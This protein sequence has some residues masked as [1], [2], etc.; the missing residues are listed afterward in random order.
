MEFFSTS[1][2]SPWEFIVRS[3][4]VY[5]ITP[6]Q[7]KWSER[8]SWNLFLRTSFTLVDGNQTEDCLA[9]IEYYYH[10][11]THCVDSCLLINTFITLSS[12]RRQDFVSNRPSAQPVSSVRCTS[13]SDRH[14]GCNNSIRV[15]QFVVFAP[16][17][18]CGSQSIL[19]QKK[20]LALLFFPLTR[21]RFDDANV[22]VS[23]L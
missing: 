4:S 13:D 12:G 10:W 16:P 15:Q 14:S 20:T 19:Y 18:A 23:A 2:S 9:L 3:S 22:R 17:V 21:R 7:L 5:T 6:S 8:L 11:T 1:S